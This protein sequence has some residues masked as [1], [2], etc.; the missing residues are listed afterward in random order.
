MN[1]PVSK[2][3]EEAPGQDDAVL[4]AYRAY[5]AALAAKQQKPRPPYGY[6]V[7]PDNPSACSARASSSTL[8][9]GSGRAK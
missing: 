8:C 2:E 5:Q 4:G 1:V 9:T 6:G 3:A 7:V